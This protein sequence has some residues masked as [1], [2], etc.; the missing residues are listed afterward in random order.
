MTRVVPDDKED[1]AIAPGVLGIVADEVGDVE[2]RDRGGRYRPLGR[3]T[4][5]AAVDQPCLA[6]AR[7][8]G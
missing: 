7:H 6:W 4:P 1:L 2:P 5:V 3:H 8:A